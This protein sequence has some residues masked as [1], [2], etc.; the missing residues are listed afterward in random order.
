MEYLTKLDVNKNFPVNNTIT[1]SNNN[2]NNINNNHNITGC[3]PSTTLNFN[4]SSYYSPHLIHFPPEHL[5]SD[6]E[7]QQPMNDKIKTK[8]NDQ[9]SMNS[10]ISTDLGVNNHNHNNNNSVDTTNEINAKRD[11]NLKIVNPSIINN[12]N[13]NNNNTVEKKTK[14]S[15]KN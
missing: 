15:T 4:V 2:N 11:H 5:N 3:L 7:H 13:N 12:N 9:L 8:P 14:I 10:M 6:F 1:N